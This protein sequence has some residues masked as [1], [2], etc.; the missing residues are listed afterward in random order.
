[1]DEMFNI[2][3][4]VELLFATSGWRGRPDAGVLPNE[5]SKSPIV[6]RGALGSGYEPSRRHVAGRGVAVDEG[7]EGG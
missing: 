4:E 3:S 5:T 6:G 7:E 2:S 1:M